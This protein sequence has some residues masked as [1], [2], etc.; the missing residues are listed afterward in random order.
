[1]TEDFRCK[2]CFQN[3]IYPLQ[4]MRRAMALSEQRALSELEQQGLIQGLEFTH[5]LAWDVLKDDLQEQGI[6]DRIGPRDATRSA[7][8]IG[9]IEDGEA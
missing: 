1:V 3:Y 2:Q 8:K 5:E 6:S 9:L 4:T 7:F